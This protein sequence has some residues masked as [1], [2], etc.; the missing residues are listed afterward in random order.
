MRTRL[1]ATFPSLKTADINIIIDAI[2]DKEIYSAAPMNRRDGGPVR[3]AITRKRNTIG[4]RC[5]TSSERNR[6]AF[7]GGP[8]SHHEVFDTLEVI[9]NQLATV[10]GLIGIL[11]RKLKPNQLMLV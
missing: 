3:G 9:H 8:G 5:S 2:K 1:V 6:Y 4:N 10:S 7:E 11:A